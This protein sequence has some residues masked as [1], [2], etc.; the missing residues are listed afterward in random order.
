MVFSLQFW[1]GSKLH[2]G[3]PQ[4]YR[5]GGKSG[6][7]VKNGDTVLTGKAGKGSCAIYNT[8]TERIAREN[9]GTQAYK[10]LCKLKGLTHIPR[11]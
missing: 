2:S 8:N 5:W 11:A 10:G 7:L 9:C 1:T 6:Q 4:K 3:T